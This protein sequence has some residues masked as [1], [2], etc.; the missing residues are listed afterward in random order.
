MSWCHFYVE[1]PPLSTQLI[2]ACLCGYLR[3]PP[4]QQAK[5]YLPC[6]MKPKAPPPMVK[7]TTPLFSCRLK[8]R[9]HRYFVC[10]QP[11]HSSR[12]HPRV[13]YY[14]GARGH[15]W[16]QIGLPVDGLGLPW[17]AASRHMTAARRGSMSASSASVERL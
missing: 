5:S 9:L 15:W 2:F 8:V 11:T 1:M 7:V 17:L 3:V 12:W 4:S 13:I 6:S 10:P 16:R 14:S